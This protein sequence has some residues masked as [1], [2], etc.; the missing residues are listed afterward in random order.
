[1][2]DQL[3]AI[4]DNYELEELVAVQWNV[5][6]AAEF[7]DAKHTFCRQEMFHDGNRWVSHVPVKCVGWHCPRCGAPTNVMG[8]HG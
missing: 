1:M 2:K 4:I 5:K 6:L 7:T 3:D 8:H